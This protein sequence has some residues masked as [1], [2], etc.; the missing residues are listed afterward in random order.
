[1]E[2]RVPRNARPK[3]PILGKPNK[4]DSTKLLEREPEGEA[5]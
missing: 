1:M 3:M 5:L 2:D 4:G